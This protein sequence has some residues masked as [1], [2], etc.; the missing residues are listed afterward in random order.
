ME[1]EISR[2]F[3][4]RVWDREVK[5]YKNALKKKRKNKKK[6]PCKLSRDED[7]IHTWQHLESAFGIRYNQYL[8]PVSRQTFGNLGMLLGLVL[9][10]VVRTDVVPDPLPLRHF[11]FVTSS[12][13]VFLHL[14]H[15]VIMCV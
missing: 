5:S 10:V 2:T 1:P 13:D 8:L 14:H 12:V 9:F 4:G 7:L 6:K 3:W 11:T 15:S